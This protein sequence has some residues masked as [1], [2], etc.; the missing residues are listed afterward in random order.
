[1]KQPRKILL[2]RM[3]LYVYRRPEVRWVLH[4]ALLE[5]FP[6]LYG[7]L[8][9][10]S[11]QKDESARETQVVMLDVSS[12]RLRDPILLVRAWRPHKDRLFTD[13]E[14]RYTK[15]HSAHDVTGYGWKDQ[16]SAAPKYVV[17]HISGLA[18]LRNLDPFAD[19]MRREA[20]RKTHEAGR[21]SR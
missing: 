11:E 12:L 20:R 1:M 7:K 10:R 15:M 13:L 17:T 21:L 5:A 8:V 9:D 2:R 14:R 4:D 3:A 6:G 18:R 16:W 19:R